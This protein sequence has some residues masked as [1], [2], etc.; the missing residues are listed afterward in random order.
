LTITIFF[1]RKVCPRSTAG[2]LPS[3][4]RDADH[5]AI[6]ERFGIVRR[7]TG[8]SLFKP[9]ETSNVASARP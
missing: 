8:G 1:V 4:T 6:L 3:P 2:A 7:T 5:L 9:P